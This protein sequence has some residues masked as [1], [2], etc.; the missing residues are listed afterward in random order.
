MHSKNITEKLIDF[1]ILENI[2]KYLTSFS[3]HFLKLLI[4]RNL[5]NPI[6]IQKFLNPKITDL[7]NPFI[8]S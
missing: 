8:S 2:Q 5:D 6:K 3:K 1:V 4:S 7:Q